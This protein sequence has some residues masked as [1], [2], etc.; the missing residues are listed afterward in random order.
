[1][2]DNLDIIP[3]HVFANSANK[4]EMLNGQLRGQGLAVKPMWRTETGNDDNL[5][6]EL[7]FFFADTEKPDFDEALAYAKRHSAPLIVVAR[8]YDA[9]AAHK[10]LAAGAEN[11][12][13][14]DHDV[15]LLAAVQQARRTR[16]NL[17]RTRALERDQ[18]R[19]RELLKEQFSNSGDAIVTVSEG[20]IVEVNEAGAAYFA[21]PDT[22]SFTGLPIL[23][24]IGSKSQHA[25]KRALKLL[26]KQNQP[27]QTRELVLLQADGNSRQS[28]IT[29]EPFA[30]EGERCARLRIAND[31]GALKLSER[32][33]ELEAENQ[34]LRGRVE[35]AQHQRPASALTQPTD[36]SPL[37]AQALGSAQV[38]VVRAVVLIRPEKPQEAYAN[39]GSVGAAELGM[40]LAEALRERLEKGDLAT[41]T[42][43][44]NLVILAT[45]ADAHSLTGWIEETVRSLGERIFEGSEHSAQLGFVAGY[46]PVN[47]IRQLE[48]LVHQAEEAATGPAGTITRYQ[49]EASAGEIDTGSWE[50][51]IREALAEH[52]YTIELDA[53]EDLASTGQ[54]RIAYPCIL[55]HD[56][57][58]ISAGNFQP[59]ALR[60]NLLETLEHRFV[61]NALRALLSL[62]RHDE[63]AGIIVPLHH[64][65]TSDEKL[66]DFLADL[67]ARTDTTRIASRLTLELD[68]EEVL[69]RVRE[70][71]Q[72][73]RRYRDL[74]CSVGLRNFTPGTA[75]EKFVALLPI[76]TLRLSP[77]FT[78]ELEENGESAGTF[79]VVVDAFKQRDIKPIATDVSDSSSMACLYNLGV[80]MIQGPIIGEPELFALDA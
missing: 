6:P 79:K 65:S 40:H 58:K 68:I 59:E 45:R 28:A 62:S 75:T 10:A 54:A 33:H 11:W 21:Y 17:S 18:Q 80:S 76:D 50:V 78:A 1:M 26:F 39:F 15:L 69:S 60:L 71:Q 23:E 48:L 16:Q 66:K 12:L 5:N 3:I 73:V 2:N 67:L 9:E 34:T 14:I 53:V 77:R 19:S 35:T 36:F 8:K 52:R 29:L 32:V 61:G 20:I 22:D 70:V 41:R 42:S 49:S 74:G 4:A 25:F 56:G 55:D 13:L 37:A 7:V 24:H 57:R 46:A 30:Y 43:D 27:Q 44:L 38:D 31:Q 72:F 47:R 51:I 64:L 63:A